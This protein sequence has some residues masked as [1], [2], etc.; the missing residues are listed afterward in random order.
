MS[1]DDLFREMCAAAD[2]WASGDISDESLHS[3]VVDYTDAVQLAALSSKQEP[4]Y[5]IEDNI[6]GTRASR[7]FS[8]WNVAVGTCRTLNLTAS[9]G[10]YGIY[11]QNGQRRSEPQS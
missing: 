4:S 6:T 5:H 8:S 11:D 3:A 2:S 1:T 7:D 10:R 9:G